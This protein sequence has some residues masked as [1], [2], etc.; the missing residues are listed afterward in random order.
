MGE[1]KCPEL[2]LFAEAC[3][4]N[5]LAVSATRAMVL[6]QYQLSMVSLNSIAYK[7]GVVE[8]LTRIGYHL[9]K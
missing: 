9:S 3:C 5:G 6:D 8:L 7:Q 2:C 1:Q 4:C